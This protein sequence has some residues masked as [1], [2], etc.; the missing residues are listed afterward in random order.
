MGKVVL[1]EKTDISPRFSEVDSLGIV[2]HGNYLNFF[3]DGREA[4]GAKYNLGYLDV[5]KHGYVTPLVKIVCDYKKTLR[6]GEKATIEVKYVDSDA[7]KITFKYII[8]KKGTKEVIATG[9]SVQVF[10]NEK[11]E[12]HLTIPPFFAAWKKKWGI[13]K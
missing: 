11:G 12:L 10:L 13:T 8:F 9:E 5:F 1:S 7:A 3:E 4:F 2:W 6:Y